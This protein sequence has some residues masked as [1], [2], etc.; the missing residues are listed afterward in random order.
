M[1]LL[2]L[3][4]DY[5]V[6]GRLLAN[7]LTGY[8]LPLAVKQSGDFGDLAAIYKQLNASFG[9]FDMYIL[10][11]STKALASGSNVDDSTYTSTEGQINDLTNERNALAD[12]IKSALNGATFGGQAISD[13][14]AQSLIAQAQDLIDQ[15]HTLAG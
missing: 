13:S 11:A 1:N 5:T 14:D 8:A 10:K 9:L 3:K 2:G 15:A 12:Q 7:D 4:D 6:D